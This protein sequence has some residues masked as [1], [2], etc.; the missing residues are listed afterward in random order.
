MCS[1]NGYLSG[2]VGFLRRLLGTESFC[3]RTA[4]GLCRVGTDIR[5]SSRRSFRRPWRVVP[6]RRHPRAPG[7]LQAAPCR[8]GPPR[9]RRDACRRTT[10]ERLAPDDDWRSAAPIESG[11]DPHRSPC[12]CTRDRGGVRWG[13]PRARPSSSLLR[14][15]KRACKHLVVSTTNSLTIYALNVNS[16][17]AKYGT[18]SP[19]GAG[20]TG[21]DGRELSWPSSVLA[22]VPLSAFVVARETAPTR[23][24]SRLALVAEQLT[25]NLEQDGVTHVQCGWT[26]SRNG[27]TKVT[28][29]GTVGSGSL[30]SLRESDWRLWTCRRRVADLPH[31]EPCR[32]VYDRDHTPPRNGSRPSALGA[33]RTGRS[34]S[35]C[36]SG[37]GIASRGRAVPPRPSTHRLVVE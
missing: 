5:A 33:A 2:V 7:D 36:S 32:W 37:G 8:G 25:A 17:P 26:G 10:V 15:R 24:V 35:A 16:Y 22:G 3:H 23:H 11:Y 9:L 30:D 4:R 20:R 12:R 21:E 18:T 13:Q 27:P 6:S 28:C 29:E 14:G 34:R 31:S 1:T 19:Q